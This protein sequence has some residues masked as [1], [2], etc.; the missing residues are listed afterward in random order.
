MVLAGLQPGTAGRCRL[1]YGL[2]RRRA[3]IGSD[4]RRELGQRCLGRLQP[5]TQL[6]QQLVL[7]IAGVGA[8]GG[9]QRVLDRVDVG[10]V[11]HA[12]QHQA[13]GADG[14]VHVVG[15]EPGLCVRVELLEEGVGV[16]LCQRSGDQF[17]Q[18]RDVR[19]RGGA[20]AGFDHGVQ[21]GA[22]RRLDAEYAGARGACNADGEAAVRRGGGG[23][24]ARCALGLHGGI[25]QR[26][27]NCGGAADL[28][29]GRRRRFPS[30][31]S[32]CRQH[33]CS[34]T[35][36][37]QMS[38]FHPCIAFFGFCYG[39]ALRCWTPGSCRTPPTGWLARPAGA[40]LREARK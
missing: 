28:G 18:R 6:V 40:I 15:G 8:V 33:G 1:Q 32:A 13:H 31:A 34:Q 35:R 37:K 17:G 24:A 14:G 20:G 39:R 25:A 38:C 21:R 9:H 10:E 22:V 30:T 7:C 19:R 16:A 3:G 4:C 26:S 36:Q 5:I 29:R 12:R 23:A 11:D 27:A 2:D